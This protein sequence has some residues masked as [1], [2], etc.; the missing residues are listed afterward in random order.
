MSFADPVWLWALTLLPVLALGGLWSHRRRRAALRQFAGGERWAGRFDREV[1]LH[2]RAVKR[3][4][5]Y[6][7]L[8]GFVLALA[9][10]QWGARLEPITRIGIDVV[11][12][13]DT[14]LSMSA[15]DLAPSRLGHARHTV[16]SLL[17]RLTGDRVAL[18]QFA[19][20]ATQVVPL[21]VDH[22]A[23]RLFL[24]AVDVASIQAPG[25]A[26]ADALRVSRAAF[27][28]GDPT[29][30]RRGQAIVLLSD[31]ED[32]EGELPAV[33]QELERDGVPVFALGTG[34]GAGTPIPLRNAAGLLTGYKKDRQGKVVTTRLEESLLERIALETGGRYWRGTPAEEEVEH[35]AEQLSALKSGEIGSDVRM[36]FEE[37]FQLFA[38]LGL[39]A[40]L[41]E[42][43]VDARRRERRRASI[44]AEAA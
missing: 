42:S 39:V 34:S 40:L 37:R 25:T 33:L 30:E 24:E 14:S 43:C 2:R 12:A 32:H 4:L 9:R 3:L 13:V 16:D 28:P 35:L 38:A 31:G 44:P 36:R 5:T 10:P 7:A 15:E 17:E 26:L 23:V 27:G 29:A 41:I 19:G 1:S 6:A 18:V 11:I 21:T 20:K 8:A 22:A